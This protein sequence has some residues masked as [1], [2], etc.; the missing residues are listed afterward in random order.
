MNLIVSFGGCYIKFQVTVFVYSYR[1]SST[2]HSPRLPLHVQH[3][4]YKC[5][6]IWLLTNCTACC[7]PQRRTVQVH[8]CD[9]V[10]C[11]LG[12]CMMPRLDDD[13]FKKLYFLPDPQPG[14]NSPGHFLPFTKLKGQDTEETYKC[15]VHHYKQSQ[16]KTSMWSTSRKA[17]WA[18]FVIHS[19]LW[20]MP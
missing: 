14:T 6:K 12:V 3:T 4:A 17:F 11:K 1:A 2:V 18:V 20:R 8:K 9:N 19:N 15:T 16:T 13:C 7:Y 10:P 5:H